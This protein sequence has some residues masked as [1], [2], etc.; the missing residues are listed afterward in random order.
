MLSSNTCSYVIP[1]QN[2]CEWKRYKFNGLSYYF[3]TLC[4]ILLSLH[5]FINDM[6]KKQTALLMFNYLFIDSIM[7]LFFSITST[8]FHSDKTIINKNI[9]RCYFLH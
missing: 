5:T 7:Q 3:G 6:A 8:I 4:I 2:A 1:L 9:A